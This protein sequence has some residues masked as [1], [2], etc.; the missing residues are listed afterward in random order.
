MC[1]KSIYF[2]K[3]LRC[4]LQTRNA[5]AIFAGKP[6]MKQLQE[7]K[8]LILY[9]NLIRQIFQRY[10]LLQP[11]HVQRITWK[12]TGYYNLCMSRG[13]LEKTLTV[14]LKILYKNLLDLLFN[15]LFLS[16]VLRKFYQILSKY[17]FLQIQTLAVQM[18]N[19]QNYTK[20]KMR[21][22]FLLYCANWTINC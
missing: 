18:Y 8:T 13:S 21:T 16:F 17:K 14:P 12:G 1:K 15:L 2:C 4:F 10:R 6:Q 22:A 5:Q 7:T 20:I 3:F 11:L 9:S 19:V